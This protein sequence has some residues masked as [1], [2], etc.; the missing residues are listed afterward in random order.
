MVLSA[1]KYDSFFLY[2]YNTL[3]TDSIIN[4]KLLLGQTPR[5]YYS[6]I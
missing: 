6:V 4:E 2:Q 5:K 3:S 1:E